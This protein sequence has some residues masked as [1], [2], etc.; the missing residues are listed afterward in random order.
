M[1]TLEELR[2][3]VDRLKER[4]NRVELNKAWETSYTRRIA[5]VV[6][7]YIVITGYFLII[8]IS[9]PLLNAMV[10]TIGFVLSTLSVSLIKKIWI[11]KCYKKR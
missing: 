1:T 9:E 3:E 11:E 4:N 2:L 7:T 6:I 8:H 5:I 10:P